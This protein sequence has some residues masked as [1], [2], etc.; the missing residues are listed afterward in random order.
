MTFPCISPCPQSILYR[1]SFLSVYAY[2]YVVN[3]G[4]IG[5]MVTLF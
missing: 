5:A 4:G 2:I 1:S 3:T